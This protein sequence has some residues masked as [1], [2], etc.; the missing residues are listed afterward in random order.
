MTIDISPAETDA[1]SVLDAMAGRKSVRRFLPGP[2]SHDT[3]RAILD[4]AARAPS[5]TNTQPWKVYAV[6]GA[7]KARVTRAVIRA[8][9]AGETSPSYAYS[10]DRWFEPYKSRRR[11]VGFDL[12]D[13]LGIAKD[14]MAGRKRQHHDN[15]EFFGAPVGLFF[16]MDARLNQGSWLDMG[17]FIGY[18]MLAARGHG[19]ETCPQAAWQ[20][21]G[22]AVR[23][24]LGI[25]DDEI[26]IC[27]MSLGRPDWS[28]QVNELETE[29]EPAEG[30]TT[31][32]AE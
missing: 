23:E 3:I 22:G 30:F 28:A 15:F 19:L 12:Y 1:I 4:T 26:L 7:A 6:E 10:P 20:T 13:L 27:G 24:A 2:V 11:K 8:S 16:T 9:D 18:V 25:S 5:G 31:F 21:Y 32:L 14:D 29:R 17:I